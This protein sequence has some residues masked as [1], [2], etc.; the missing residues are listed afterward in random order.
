MISA[1]T[2][3]IVGAGLLG[4]SVGLALAR[5]PWRVWLVDAHER[6][7]SLAVD[8]G[9]GTGG[10]SEENPE[11][12]LLAVPPGALQKVMSEVAERFPQ[13]TVTDVASIKSEPQRDAERAGLQARFV[14][15]HP[16][17]GRERSGGAAAQADLFDARPW[18]ICPSSASEPHR[19]ELVERL[20]RDCGADPIRLDAQA[21]DSAVALVS[22]LPHVAACAVAGQLSDA[23][24]ITMTLAGPGLRDTV[25][26]AG[27]DP[28]LWMQILGGNAAAVAPLVG[29]LATDLAELSTALAKLADEP[30]QGTL[31][32]DRQVDKAIERF[33]AAGQEGHARI[34]GKH[35]TAPMEYSVIPVVIP[36]EPGALGRLFTTVAK[37]GASVEDISLE[38]SPG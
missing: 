3:Q 30:S 34:P 6:A 33:L 26:V 25:R 11:L 7:Q 13:S 17:A 10:W 9:A 8:L 31:T 12:V 36:D 16:M 35:G 2:L 22:H 21:H 24:S 14:G 29:R 38:H 20:A 27:G 5:T 23:D 18:A 28:Q 4:T 37:S 19:V 15:G 1:P 32:K